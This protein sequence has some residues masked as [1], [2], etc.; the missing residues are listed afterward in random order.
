VLTSNG[1]PHRETADSGGE[2]IVVDLCD[3][4]VMHVHNPLG[5]DYGFDW[6]I[7]DGTGQQVLTGTLRLGAADTAHRIHCL[8]S[9]LH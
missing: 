4:H 8:L 6:D 5:P 7:T 2:Y 9:T 3:S 1:T